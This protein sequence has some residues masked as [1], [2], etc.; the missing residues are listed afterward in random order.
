MI[1]GTALSEKPRNHLIECLLPV[2]AADNRTSRFLYDAP[3]E[4]RLVRNLGTL[5]ID[6]TQGKGAPHMSLGIGRP[7]R[8]IREELGA[9]NQNQPDALI[10]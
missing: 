9:K 7:Q 2:W 6:P 8:S 5:R 3:V 4:D 1:H 10:L